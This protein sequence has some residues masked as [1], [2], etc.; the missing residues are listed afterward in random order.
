MSGTVVRLL[1]LCGC[2]ASA[3]AAPLPAVVN[4]GN[5]TQ[6]AVCG[7]KT[8]GT[9]GGG[10]LSLL[11]R[12]LLYAIVLVVRVSSVN[13]CVCGAVSLC[14]LLRLLVLTA[15][16]FRYSVLTFA[17]ASLGSRSPSGILNFLCTCLPV[18]SCTC[19]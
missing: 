4:Q 1:V 5:G 2:L 11:C 15:H 13:G 16:V 8:C 6:S 3:L 12:H 9:P 10:L 18:Q 17:H 14:V 19:T 7:L